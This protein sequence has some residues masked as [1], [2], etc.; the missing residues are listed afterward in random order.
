MSSF[1]GIQC[2]LKKLYRNGSRFHKHTD[3]LAASYTY[4]PQELNAYQ[5]HYLKIMVRHCY[6]NVPYYRE[7]FMSLGLKP[8]DIVTRE[9]LKKLPILDKKMVQSDFQKFISKK[10]NNFL[11]KVGKTSGSTGTPGKFIRN[12]DSINFEN[13]CVWRSWRNAGDHGKKR[14]T[15]RGD[16]IVPSGQTEPPFWR[17]NPANDELQMS[18]YHLSKQNSIHYIQKTMEFQPKVLFSS[19]S[20]SSLF[21]KFFRLHSVPYQFEA[22]FTSS[23]SLEDDVR[24]LVEDIFQCPVTDWY[25]QAER[26]AAIGQCRA[27][28]YHIQEDYSIVELLPSEDNTFE[29]V[30]SQIRNFAMP[31]LRYRTNDF[32]RISGDPDA[33]PAPCSCGAAFRTVENIIGRSFGYLYTPEGFEIPITAAIPIGVNN[34]IETQ[35]YQEQKGEVILKVLSNGRFCATDREQLISNTLKYTSP[36]MKVRVEEVD[37]I[38]RGPNGKFI[39]IINKVPASMN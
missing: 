24:K 9:D 1:F 32:V 21:A 6:E 8:E 10:H 22:I 14:L 30:G 2:W 4:S 12:F 15:L 27:G 17:Y 5:Q 25:G 26:V 36:H 3:A 7:T 11:C 31:L 28:R 13:A 37:E 34:I 19:P 38:P 20:M 18:G 33:F 16:V 39:N 35:F 29:I 23:E